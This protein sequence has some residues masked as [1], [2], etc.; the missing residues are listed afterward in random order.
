MCLAAAIC[1]GSKRR[2][3]G[4][5]ARAWRSR[6]VFASA[7]VGLGGFASGSRPHRLATEWRS[8]YAAASASDANFGSGDF[9]AEGFFFIRVSSLAAEEPA[10]AG[11][12]IPSRDYSR[13]TARE[14]PKNH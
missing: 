12:H 4:D 9:A 2:E 1:S 6:I 7:A 11:V 5:F 14:A 8:K 3:M 10:F 13:Q